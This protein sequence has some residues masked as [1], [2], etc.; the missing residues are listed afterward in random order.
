MGRVIG[1]CLALVLCIV[2]V[3]GI[4]IVLPI[5]G[6]LFVCTHLPFECKNREAVAMD[7]VSVCMGDAFVGQN[8]E[9]GGK[10]C[11]KKIKKMLYFYKKI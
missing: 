2:S 9:S 6:T 3:V 10:I 5:G 8:T 7:G 11:R 4:D 1:R